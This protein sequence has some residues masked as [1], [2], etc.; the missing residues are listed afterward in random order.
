MSKRKPSAQ[1][2]IDA[3]RFEEAAS[4]LESIIDRIEQGEVELE[5]SLE[6]Y[7]RGLALVKRCRAILDSAAK[8]IEVS[9]VEDLQDN[10]ED[11]D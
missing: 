8:D 5:D 9:S 10:E 1:K 6:A 2:D 11:G 4:E 3:L 7:R